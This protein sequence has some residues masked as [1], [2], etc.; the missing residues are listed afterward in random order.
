[1]V[2]SRGNSETAKSIAIDIEQSQAQQKA[3]RAQVA[4]K[5]K[6]VTVAFENP[7]DQLLTVL[8]EALAGED[9]ISEYEFRPA[10]GDVFV[11]VAGRPCLRG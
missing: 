4:R 2:R 6:K 9:L 7:L 1:M 11:P 5:R 10:H 8:S 3:K